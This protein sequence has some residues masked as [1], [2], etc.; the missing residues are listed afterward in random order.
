MKQHEKLT[1]LRLI[2]G[3]DQQVLAK[4]AKITQR[5]MT[6]IEKGKY[7]LKGERPELFSNFFG[8][9]KEWFSH[10][11]PPIFEQ[12]G[13]WQFP[14]KSIIQK[15]KSTMVRLTRRQEKF[16]R[17]ELG[18]FFDENKATGYAAASVKNRENTLFFLEL[19]GDSFLLIN[20]DIIMLDAVKE[21]LQ[22]IFFRKSFAVDADVLN[23]IGSPY[24]ENI[25]PD[26]ITD[27][28]KKA[29]FAVKKQFVKKPTR[30]KIASS[31]YLL[32]E[33][34]A[35]MIIEKELNVA[36]IN[37]CVQKLKKN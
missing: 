23:L 21:A 7:G 2:T 36:E 4:T 27:L 35:R 20:A 8:C 5:A 22:K 26:I 14:S 31:R 1:F 9:R 24:D 19:A 11:E 6:F 16:V 10:G 33:K 37:A 15:E 34:I 13:Y 32:V 18:N 12:W 25:D 3:T 29:G 17:A 30:N 28:F